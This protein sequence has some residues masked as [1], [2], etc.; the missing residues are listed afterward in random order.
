MRMGNFLRGAVVG[1]REMSSRQPRVGIDHRTVVPA[2]ALDE[3]DR[4]TAG[5][6]GT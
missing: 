4:S 1:G 3:D 5:T 2:P 6:D